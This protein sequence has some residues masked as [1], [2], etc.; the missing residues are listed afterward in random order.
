MQRIFFIGDIHGCSKT[1]RKMIT[2]KIGVRKTDVI[3]CIGDYIDRGNDS[4]GVIDFILELRKN[5]FEIHTLRGNHE[6]M[7]LD[8]AGNGYSSDLWMYNGGHSTLES[9]NAG[10][11]DQLDPVYLD[12]FRST[13]HYVISDDFIA[14]HAGLDFSAEDPFGEK[15]AM[16]WIRD[17][18]VD[19]SFMKGRLLIH[20]HT[21]IGRYLVVS[22][23][24]DDSLNIDGGCV[25]KDTPGMG[26]LFALNFYEQKFIEVRNID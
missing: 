17:F 5:D 9:F 8:A 25:Y 13:K 7:L 23:R 12:F 26:S 22:Q 14:V 15:E 1:F 24:F 16:L 4:K 19:R 11:A 3:Y 18:S 2:D 6:Q 21:P 20:G 10:S